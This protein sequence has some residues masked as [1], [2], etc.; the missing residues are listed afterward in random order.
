MGTVT[1]GRAR[2]PKDR[3]LAASVA[4]N[5]VN[6]AE[7]RARD[8]YFRRLDEASLLTWEQRLLE[9]QEA[10]QAYRAAVG[11]YLDGLGS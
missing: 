11:A 8:D 3:V 5:E 4:L 7:A 6:R 10:Q 1:N 2:A 9:Q